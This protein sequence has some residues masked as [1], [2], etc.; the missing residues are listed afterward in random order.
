VADSGQWSSGFVRDHLRV[1]GDF[2]VGPSSGACLAMVDRLAAMGVLDEDDVVVVPF[3]DR[4]D[5]YPD[6]DLTGTPEGTPAEKPT[7][8]S[9]PSALDGQ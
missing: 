3:P 2:L 9:R 4:G 7:P 1:D 8:L 6:R 5:R